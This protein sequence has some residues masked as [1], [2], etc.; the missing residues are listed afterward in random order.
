[1]RASLHQLDGTFAAHRSKNVLAPAA[2]IGDSR[3]AI[4]SLMHSMVWRDGI[5]GMPPSR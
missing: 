5:A 2:E 1:M 3:A 4:Y